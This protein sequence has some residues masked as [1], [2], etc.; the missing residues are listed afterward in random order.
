MTQDELS[1]RSVCVKKNVLVVGM[2]FFFF[3]GWSARDDNVSH[4]DGSPEL[5]GL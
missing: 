1:G 4:V 3:G 5:L 2:W